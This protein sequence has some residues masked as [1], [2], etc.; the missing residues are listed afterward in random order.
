MSFK[1]F[2]HNDRAGTECT[3]GKLDATNTFQLQQTDDAAATITELFSGQASFTETMGLEEAVPVTEVLNLIV[4]LD[5][6]VIAFTTLRFRVEWLTGDGDSCT[7]KD[8]TQWSASYSTSNTVVTETGLNATQ[9][10]ATGSTKIRILV[11]AIG[12]SFGDAGQVEFDIGNGNSF[13]EIPFG[14]GS[15]Q[16][17]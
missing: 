10:A 17:F 8:W 3:D 5:I 9:D 1:Y 4:S 14:G 13:L 15:N 7:L 6:G 11:Q 12:T 2:V 16:I